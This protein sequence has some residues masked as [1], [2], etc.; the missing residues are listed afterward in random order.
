MKNKELI[1]SV[2]HERLT[3]NSLKHGTV[4]VLSGPWGCGKTYLWLNDIL[5]L[6]SGKSAITLSLFGLESIAALKTQLMNQC[7]ILKAC[8]LGE[9]KLKRALSGSKNLLLEGF[10]K[11]LKGV[12]S[13]I[14]TN[15]L[16][17]NIDPLQLVDENLIVC[18]D[19]IE[20]ISSK[21][22][23]DEVFGLTNYLAEHKH[24]KVLLIMNE[25][26]LLKNDNP[27]AK[28][29]LK[30]KERLV[31]YHLQVN[32]DLES[33]FDL[34]SNQYSKQTE[35]YDYLINNKLLVLQSMLTSKCENLRTLKKIIEGIAE[36]L[37]QEEIELEPKLIPSMVALQI[38]SSEGKLYDPDFYNFNEM[39]LMIASKFNEQETGQGGISEKRK[40]FHK[41]Y[42]GN[43]EGY[44]FIRAFYEQIKYGYFDWSELKKE[45]NPE[46]PPQDG[47][48]LALAAPQSRE[49]W[50]LSDE[51][52]AT[53]I[54]QI[55]GYIFSN[56]LISTAKL[57]TA[58]VYLK[59]AV[60]MS[61]M[62]LN[63]ETDK[64]IRERLSNNALSGDESFNH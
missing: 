19:D 16:S 25:E 4:S 24:C 33:A 10:K 42:F 2:L 26:A 6:L 49:W 50:Y 44:Y 15:L 30:Y 3:D 62:K 27:N 52:Y 64:R 53:W 39:S 21:I 14:G 43:S 36:I 9:G 1:R 5:P 8:S 41:S 60:D 56:Q 13:V 22:G 34:F 11:A 7:L 47:F 37:H 54:N 63:P 31:D 28:T 12:D 46:S 57:I 58:A 32:T 55:E 45:I 20:R 29:M 18:F 38:E 51:E 17:W 48:T 23:L 40:I 61:G 59:H 35:L